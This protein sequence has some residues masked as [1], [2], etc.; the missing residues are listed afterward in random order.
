MT[1]FSDRTHACIYI[2]M[3]GISTNIWQLLKVNVGKYAIHGSY[4]L[5][6]SVYIC[7]FV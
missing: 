4:E 7:I 1:I 3:Y 2:Y 6:L 5:F